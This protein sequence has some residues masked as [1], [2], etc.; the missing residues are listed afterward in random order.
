MFYETKKFYNALIF[1]QNSLI[2]LKN[3]FTVYIQLFIKTQSIL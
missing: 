2:L 3:V 1:V